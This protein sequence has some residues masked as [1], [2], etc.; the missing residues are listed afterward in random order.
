MLN[1]N[2]SIFLCSRK[3]NIAK[4]PENTKINMK[5]KKNKNIVK[6]AKADWYNHKFKSEILSDVTKQYL[7]TPKNTVKKNLYR[8]SGSNKYSVSKQIKSSTLRR[9]TLSS[10]FSFEKKF[11]THILSFQYYSEPDWKI[12]GD[13]RRPHRNLFGGSK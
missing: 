8:I 13:S 5:K 6:H 3:T 9:I 12:V 7:S 4:Q 1:L 10:R 2:Y 11:L